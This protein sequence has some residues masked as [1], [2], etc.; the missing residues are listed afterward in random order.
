MTASRPRPSPRPGRLIQ[1]LYGLAVVPAPVLGTFIPPNVPG[2][3]PGMGARAESGVPGLGAMA[4]SGLFS[5]CSAAL[6][7]KVGDPGLPGK[8]PKVWPVPRPPI[9]L[10]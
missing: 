3:V 7:S 1:A 2:D 9:G 6:G 5:D 4:E 8:A 10:V